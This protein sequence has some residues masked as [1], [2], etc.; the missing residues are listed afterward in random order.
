MRK[1]QKS[2]NMKHSK[3]EKSPRTQKGFSE[4]KTQDL[5][6]LGPVMI[7]EILA[8]LVPFHKQDTSIREMIMIQMDPTNDLLPIIKRH[9]CR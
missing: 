7:K 1:S 2:S 8:D 6:R 4:A 5:K 3:K 9:F